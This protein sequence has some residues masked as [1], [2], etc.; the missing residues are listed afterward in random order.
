MS[1]RLEF[2]KINEK[3]W[4]WDAKKVGKLMFIALCHLRRRLRHRGNNIW[5]RHPSRRICHWGLVV[6]CRLVRRLCRH[7]RLGLVVLSVRRGLCRHLYRHHRLVLVGLVCHLD[8]LVLCHRVVVLVLEHL[9]LHHHVVRLGLVHRGHLVVLVVRLGLVDHLCLGLRLCR[10][11]HFYHFLLVDLGVQLDLV[12]MGCTVVELEFGSIQEEPGR[13]IQGYLGYLVCLAFLAF[14]VYL[15][16]QFGQVGNNL[17]R[18]QPV[19]CEWF[20]YCGEQ[21]AQQLSRKLYFR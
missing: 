10:H 7:F 18:N 9:C 16:D 1:I 12:G 6:L 19:V 8:R 4:R 20:C 3:T 13:G 14:L 5:G 2:E 11:H 17:R 15:V 21:L